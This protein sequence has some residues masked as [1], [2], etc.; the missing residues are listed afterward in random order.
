MKPLRKSQLVTLP[1]QAITAHLSSS[2]LLHD[3]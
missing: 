2:I 3:R 1:L